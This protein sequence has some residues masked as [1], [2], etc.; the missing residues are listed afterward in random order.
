MNKLLLCLALLLIFNSVI[1]SS[2]LTVEEAI[3]I[4]VNNSYEL[5]NQEDVYKLSLKERSLNIRQWFPD[6]SIGFNNSDTVTL[7]GVDY[8]TK[9][10][11]AKV[12]QLIFDGGVSALSSS[13][14]KKQG[15]LDFITM[16]TSTQQLKTKI[17]SDYSFI[18]LLE[19]EIQLKKEFLESGKQEL[20]I[21]ELKSNQGSI[22][23]LEKIEATLAVKQLGLE[24]LQLEDQ[25]I[26]SMNEFKNLLGL[27][28]SSP[29]KCNGSNYN[30]YKGVVLPWTLE[31]Y[32]NISL[33]NNLDYKKS[34]VEIDKI[35]TE[36]FLTKS[37]LLPTIK[38]SGS[39]GL[40]GSE[41]PLNE[42]NYNLSVDISFDKL[43][44]PVTSNLSAGSQ[45][46]D[47]IN[48]SYNGEISP[49]KVVT[50]GYSN[51]KLQIDLEA[52]IYNMNQTKEKVPQNATTL[53]NSYNLKKEQLLLQE[54]LLTLEEEKM[55]IIKIQFQQGTIIYSNWIS[56]KNKIKETQNKYLKTIIETLELEIQLC[57]LIGITPDSLEHLRSIK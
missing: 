37:K 48:R 8:H 14:S 42:P 54:E 25:F 56:A 55:K 45:S 52:A 28:V 30:N 34:I 11:N 7:N 46:K 17:W 2:S 16:E 19:Y 38:L 44:S 53:Y 35:K 24:L 43:S 10:L 57:L 3:N 20:K 22:T 39:I 15:E 12:S 47:V 23:Q 9:S 27:S 36:I 31:E 41:Y 13:L 51:K 33:N 1:L 18:T 4:G 5:K 21:V 26:K 32:K 6:L 40:S 50:S 29:I 49:L